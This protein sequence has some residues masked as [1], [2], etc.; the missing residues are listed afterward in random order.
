MA[1]RKSFQETLHLKTIE[2]TNPDDK[3][4]CVVYQHPFGILAIYLASFI[5]LVGGIV[6]S[7]LFLPEIIG[8]DTQAYSLVAIVVIAISVLVGVLLV[9]A[10]VVYRQTKLT[11]TDRNVVQIIQ[12]GLLFR[13]VSQISLA[14]VED[15]TSE[16]KGFFAA[17]FNF[18]TLRIETAGEQANFN[19][20]FCPNPNRVAHIILESKDNFLVVTGQTGSY[21]NRP[22]GSMR[23]YSIQKD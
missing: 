8:N 22:R 5:C 1:G 16:Q 6:L 4:M 7:G 15:V 17:F 14:N 9:L 2:T 10:T 18:G 20:S 11:V 21:R 12:K 3:V 13:Q 19:F 23:D